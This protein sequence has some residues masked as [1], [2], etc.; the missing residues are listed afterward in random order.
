MA[1]DFQTDEQLAEQ[2]K[3]WLRENGAWLAGGV[4]LGLAGLFGWQQWQI[5]GQRHAVEASAIYEMLAVAA[6]AQ[7]LEDAEASLARLA[8]DY[9]GSPYLDQGRLLIAKLYFNRSKPDDAARYLREVADTGATAEIRRVAR[10]RLA[11]VLIYQEQYDK[12]LALLREPGAGA[13]EPAYHEVRG[14]AYA[15]M[16]KL[17]E[18]RTEYQK[19]VTAAD[20]GAVLDRNFIQAKLDDLAVPEPAPTADAAA[21]AP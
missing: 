6:G 11:R 18:A 3:G 10:L 4:V 20:D 9:S 12:A 5:A 16:G 2:A 7:K 14:D 1:D 13:F 19:A 21:A 17:E 8:A 15:A